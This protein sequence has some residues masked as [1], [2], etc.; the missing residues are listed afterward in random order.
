[1]IDEEQ[2]PTTESTSQVPAKENHEMEID[3]PVVEE[4]TAC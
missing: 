3:T 2:T 1:L 4:L